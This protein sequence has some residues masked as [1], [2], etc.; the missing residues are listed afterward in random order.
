MVLFGWMLSALT[1]VGCNKDKDATGDDTGGDT[2]V[3]TCTVEISETV[4]AQDESFYYRGTLEVYFTEADD[5]ATVTL[6]DSA[7]TA[8]SG[9][10]SWSEDGTVLYFT[11]D[12]ALA[13]STSYTLTIDY[14]AGSPDVS[15]MT[16]ELGAEASTSD[17]TGKAYTIDLAS[18]R[19][20]EPEGIGSILGDLLEQ[21]ILV[22]VVS[23]TDTDLEMIGAISVAGTTEQ[24]VCAASIDF[25]AADFSENP[26]FSVGPE[27]TTIAVAGYSATIHGLEISGAFA[28]DLSYFGGGKLAGTIDSRDLATI[29]DLADLTGCDGTSDSCLCEFIAG[30]G[31][32][33]CSAC[34]DG[35]PLCLTLLADQ[36]VA[37]EIDGSLSVITDADV[38]ANPDCAE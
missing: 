8:V 20:I 31:L 30:T 13:P 12:S 7:G 23:A 25:P 9:T 37:E 2:N 4:P 27:D 19:F 34:D 28:P 24:D 26:F 15:F 36:I 32:A 29:P 18:A 10:S 38:D 33:N 17:L 6:A 11:P 3:P 1:L 22:G 5:T 35:E 14:C 16:S 21:N